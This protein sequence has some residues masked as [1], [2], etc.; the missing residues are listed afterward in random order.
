M[1]SASY[2]RH[3]A[4]PLVA[5]NK[6]LQAVSVDLENQECVLLAHP[7][8]S[9]DHL[10]EHLSK[11]SQQAAGRVDGVPLPLPLECQ[12]PQGSAGFEVASVRECP[13]SGRESAYFT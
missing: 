1:L 11:T 12:R 10:V 9:V 4:R 6:L 8:A 7:D 3:S 2:P 5:D 13:S